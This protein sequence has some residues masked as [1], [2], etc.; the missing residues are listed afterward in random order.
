MTP[1]QLINLLDE[2]T[3]VGLASRRKKRDWEITYTLPVSDIY[4]GADILSGVF[5]TE[6]ETAEIA[7][8]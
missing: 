6:E 1:E 2:M 3:I 4:S 5:W 7:P 8:G